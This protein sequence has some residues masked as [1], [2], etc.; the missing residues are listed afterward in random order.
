MKLSALALAAVLAAGSAHGAT[1]I[2]TVEG[3]E[4]SEGQVFVGICDKSL[5]ADGCPFGQKRA[6]EPGPMEFTFEIPPGRYAVAGYHDVNA[7]EKFDYTTLGLPKEPNAL[8]NDANRKMWPGFKDA[9]IPVEDGTVNK[10]SVRMR[11]W[12]SGS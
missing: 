3:V 8:S 7:N 2:V 1:L 10:V 5:S 6:A 4:S 11:R 12:M 9:V